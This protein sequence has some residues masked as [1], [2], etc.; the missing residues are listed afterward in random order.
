MPDQPRPE[1]PNET[2]EADARTAAAALTGRLASLRRVARVLLV[3]QR[4][5]AVLAMTIAGLIGL[6]LIDFV[7]RAPGWV[8][9][10]FLGAAVA[11]VLWLVW[12]RLFAVARFN[13]PLSE[14]A[15][16]L[17]GLDTDGK[18]GARGV[19]ASGTQFAL[20]QGIGG[21][22]RGPA[23]PLVRRA[24]EA[25]DKLGPA[26]VLKPAATLA[27]VGALLAA[28]LTVAGFF[29]AKPALA[30]TGALRVLAPWT[31]AQWPKRTDVEDYTLL[32][33]HPL[34]S[35][36][37]LRGV[38]LASTQSAQDTRVEA[39]YSLIAPDGSRGPERRVLL[40]SQ[41]RD[42]D[43]PG[44]D[45][46][47]ARSGPLFERL[48]EPAS[49]QEQG[50]AAPSA[51]EYALVTSDDRTEPR[52]VLLVQPP[53]VLS[54]RATV[55]P[56]EYAQRSAGASSAKTD[57]GAGAD[58][59]AVLAG[60]LVGS[61][62]GL[63]LTLNKPVPVPPAEPGPRRAW[64]ALALG[65]QFA[66]LVA[67]KPEASLAVAVAGEQ[68][69]L[70]WVVRESV[71]LPVRP[72]DEFGLGPD[73]E[74]AFRVE[75]RT[76]R[77]PEAAVIK[78]AD[79]GEVLPSAVVELVAE[80]R[81]DVALASVSAQFQLA[82]RVSGSES[83][84][85]EPA[86]DWTAA[87]AAAPNTPGEG[88]KS[89]RAVASIDLDQ[90]KAKPGE[91]LWLSAL[92]ADAFELDGV[93]HEP[94][95]SV[96][97]KI[98]I[99]STDQL[100]EQVWNEL[101]TVRRGAIRLAEQQAQL[102]ENTK[103]GRDPGAVARDQTGITESSA[104][105]G[106]A[107]ERL[108][109]RLARNNLAEHE[110]SRVLD[111]ARSL[112]QQTREQSETAGR[113]LRDAQQAAA[114][115]D[116]AAK[117]RAGE[118]GEQAQDRAQR[119][120]EQLAE[121]LDRGQDTWSARRALERLIEEQQAL[122][123]QSAQMGR[124]T[125]GRQTSELEAGQQ[126]QIEEMAQKQDELSRRADEAI[127][128]MQQR[129]DKL[130]ATEPETAQA[131]TEAAQR[132]QRQQVPE[133]LQR[134]ARDVRDNKQQSANQRQDRAVRDMQQMLEQMERASRSR[135]ETLTRELQSL[136]ESLDA[137]I[138]RQETEL[139]AL[140]DAEARGAFVGLDQSMIQLRVNTLAVAEQA[141]A[142]G[143]ETRPAADLIAEAA[144][145]QAK[146]ISGLREEP[147]DPAGVRAFEQTSLDKLLAARKQVSEAAAQAQQRN[148]RRQ[149]AELRR[150]YTEL[151][152]QQTDLRVR[153]RAA[154]GLEA[155]RRQRAAARELFEP[156]DEVR[157]NA[158][159]LAARTPDI[160]D[161]VMFKFAHERLDEATTAAAAGLGEGEA[162]AAVIARQGTAIRVLSGILESLADSER[163]QDDFRE[164]PDGQQSQQQGGGGGEGQQR[165][166]PPAAELRNLRQAQAEA[167]TLTREAAESPDPA[168]AKESAAE[169]AKLQGALVDKA[170]AILE[171]LNQQQQ[172][173]PR[174]GVQPRPEPNAG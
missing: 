29:A 56:P 59:R 91:E 160:A 125:T 1:S 42:A 25:L 138:A 124:E 80:G 149:R 99:I 67:D 111:E 150:A 40:T 23:H 84:A 22:G 105:Q 174:P 14:F 133:E 82:R 86:A 117:Q 128:D 37:P 26:R 158:S 74:S 19:L 78:P 166:I 151:L 81:D 152:D 140:G 41:D 44:G 65:E 87:G 122:R 93:G 10:A 54:A 13:P 106:Q 61:R 167:L 88:A 164:A 173:G 161:S 101:G 55:T 68:W 155:G 76:D 77:P 135:D 20:D 95:R 153:T 57:L 136:L 127:R 104:R 60:V 34:G 47:V 66:A 147:V 143:R 85:V 171:K 71:R 98:R 75:A 2:P 154:A 70:S 39:V 165:L 30:R 97:R 62:L 58:E 46:G 139:G 50:G 31:D 134:A 109:E 17:E 21:L 63:D 36:L 103:A 157:K 52:R 131:M 144:G 168:V 32:D 79:D 92:A 89:L 96:I 83:G 163:S 72:S 90:L 137:L 102:R 108:R 107:V 114:Q 51:I 110:L 113:S 5:A 69:S 27:A 18:A 115:N 4:V 43:L 9:G 53:R 162:T 141:R 35:A 119:T 73:V 33:F 64:L 45:D 48:I 6:A 15:L 126:R 28:G 49:L 148:T 7:L 130:R 112:L 169:A 121:L 132:G 16:R 100:V 142:A 172:Q 120:L 156:Q 146:A 129:A 12:R 145:A 8:R 116:Q 3:S 11:L 159:A 170:K 94:V 118:A 38:L 24:L 123:E